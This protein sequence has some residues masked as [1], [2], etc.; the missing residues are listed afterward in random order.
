LT[1]TKQPDKVRFE[2]RGNTA[3]II[4]EFKDRQCMMK[5]KPNQGYIP[6]I[7]GK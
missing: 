4:Q 7:R 6:E 2:G 1:F 3:L 5:I